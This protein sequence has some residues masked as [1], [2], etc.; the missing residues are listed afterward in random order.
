MGDPGGRGMFHACGS[1]A[2]RGRAVLGEGQVPMGPGGAETCRTRRGAGACGGWGE[3]CPGRGEGA[4]TEHQVGLAGAE[5]QRAGGAPARARGLGGEASGFR[6]AVKV[7]R[8]AVWC[9]IGAATARG[10][11]RS[12]RSGARAHRPVTVAELEDRPPPGGPGTLSRSLLCELPHPHAC[13]P[14]L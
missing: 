11:R 1:E 9:D 10:S 7:T 14:H 8:E 13:L 4:T 6:A 2:C 3:G 12:D 5:Q